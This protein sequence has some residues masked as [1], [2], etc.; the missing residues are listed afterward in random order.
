MPPRG[1]D[2]EKQEIG[3]TLED[4][5]KR[6]HQ[7]SPSAG[8]PGSRPRDAWGAGDGDSAVAVMAGGTDSGSGSGGGSRGD[9][10]P[11]HTAPGGARGMLHCSSTGALLP[12]GAAMQSFPR[13]PKGVG[14][15]GLMTSSSMPLSSGARSTR[16]IS[17]EQAQAGDVSGMGIEGGAFTSPQ[18]PP[19][20]ARRATSLRVIVDTTGG[21]GGAEGARGGASG[22]SPTPPSSTRPAGGGGGGGS[23]VRF[24]GSAA[25]VG[26]SGGAGAL[27]PTPPSPLPRF[28]SRSVAGA[29]RGFHAIQEGEA[30]A[31]GA[32]EGWDG[33]AGWVGALEPG[34]DG[35]RLS[36][37]SVGGGGARSSMQRH[38][39][40]PR[41][42]PAYPSSVPLPVGN[43]VA[44][45]ASP[46]KAERAGL[47]ASSS[48]R[49]SATVDGAWG[50]DDSSRR[51]RYSGETGGGGGSVAW[52]GAGSVSPRGVPGAGGGGMLWPGSL[53][54]SPSAKNRIFPS[55][56]G[57]V[58]GAGARA[59][60]GAG[61]EV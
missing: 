6:Q 8:G 29:G 2:E 3:G 13:A 12:A 11:G 23:D 32:L 9:G 58:A 61:G 27:S 25:I 7:G 60:A 54:R 33:S 45:P 18:P 34:L 20:W 50:G 59:G 44:P 14:G 21:V 10:D 55:A 37:R 19:L 31:G 4:T 28:S 56:G 57:A 49:V 47:E 48:R 1:G 53:S 51:M 35:E 16:S 17:A 41:T 30:A 15:G 40:Q 42:S 38:G 22:D 43:E 26:V 36:G 52:G 46:S 5:A 39:D 24:M